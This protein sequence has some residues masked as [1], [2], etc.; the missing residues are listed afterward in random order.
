MNG[1]PDA[2]RI[3]LDTNVFIETFEGGDDTEI[4]RLLASLFASGDRQEPPRFCTSELTLAEVLVK[5]YRDRDEALLLR[6]ESL[7]RSSTWLEVGPIDTQILS[8]AAL[9]R[10]YHSIRLPDAVHLSTA[11]HFGC[12]R[13]LTSDTGMKGQYT[14]RYFGTGGRKCTSG[15]VEVLRPDRDEIESLL[16]Q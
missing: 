4:S 9:L 1:K 8:G 2:S 6:Y 10:S 16:R 11:L 7:L 3:Y 14:L 5:P 12:T 15:S 13:I